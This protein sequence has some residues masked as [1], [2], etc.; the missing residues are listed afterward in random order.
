MKENHPV[1]SDLE[2]A[3]KALIA[4][5]IPPGPSVQLNQQLQ[6]QLVRAEKESESV[7][8]YLNKGDSNM[9][10]FSSIAAAVLAL[11]GIGVIYLVFSSTNEKAAYAGMIKQLKNVKSLSFMTRITMPDHHTT[12]IRTLVLNEKQVREEMLNPSAKDEKNAKAQT[13]LIHGHNKTLTLDLQSNTVK[14]LNKGRAPST[15]SRFSS[16]LGL[17]EKFKN[18]HEDDAKYLGKRKVDGKSVLKYSYQK[19]DGHYVV[20][21]DPESDLPVKV[22]VTGAEGEKKSQLKIE[23]FDFVWNPELDASLFSMDVPAGFRLEEQT[24]ARN[25]DAQGREALVGILGF[26]VRINDDQFPDSFNLF[27][28]TSL[29]SKMKKDGA[30][31]AEQRKH[32]REIFAKGLGKAELATASHEEFRK[33]SQ[34][35]TKSS[36]IGAGYLHMLMETKQWYYQGKGIRLG[37]ADKIVAWWYPKPNSDASDA[38]AH[39]LYGD[40]KIKKMAIADLPAKK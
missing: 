10:R 34:D 2:K 18:M 21:L 1:P 23:M 38:S 25:L 11:I 36:A 14:V 19:A 33:A 35:F 7:P 31:G 9:R 12:L 8:F 13:V 27:V 28:Y 29:L 40:L 37:D 26:Y 6:S 15:A 39:V 4:M 5:E 24:T 22:M 17:I 16:G 20:W 32:R 30:S 3:T